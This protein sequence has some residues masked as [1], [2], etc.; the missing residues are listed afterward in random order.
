MRRHLAGRVAVAQRQRVL[1]RRLHTRREPT[2]RMI[3]L[4]QPAPAQQM[5]EACLMIGVHEAAVRRPPIARKHAGEVLAEDRGGIA[6]PAAGANRV[7]GGVGRGE[8]PEPVQG[9]RHFPARLVWTHDRTAA[10]LGT[11]RLVG[12]RRAR[13]R[14][15]TEMHERPAGDREAEAI[16]EQGGDVRERQAEALVQHDDRRRRFGADLHGRC[17]ERVGGLPRMPALH[18]PAARHAR[19]DVHAELADDG[20]DHRQIFLIPGDNMRA[21]PVAATRGTRAGPRGVVD[22]IDSPGHRARAVATVAGPRAPA[23]RTAAALSMGF[24]ERCGLTDAR[25]A[26]RIE[27][28]L[29]SLVAALQPIALTLGAR[30]R[31]AQ[32]RNRLPL[33]PDQ[34]VALV[35]RRR[36]R[37]IGHPPVMPEDRNLYKYEILDRRCSCA[38]TR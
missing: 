4:K 12:R 9:A 37:C 24:G 28:I 29:E 18:A 2:A 14:A 3:D 36:R 10:D 22:L 32:S 1:Q 11:E 13:R 35:G 5:R 6:K 21:L 27:L 25:S 33:S 30:Q 31:I 16:A 20:T 23:R 8:R 15:R 26:R 38:E 34:R 19:A 17:A 7:D